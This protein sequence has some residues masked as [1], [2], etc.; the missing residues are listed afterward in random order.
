VRPLKRKGTA[1]EALVANLTHRG[2]AGGERPVLRKLTSAR[3]PRRPRGTASR[4]RLE[5]NLA[6]E[7][8]VDEPDAGTQQARLSRRLARLELETVAVSGDGNC[9]FRSMARQVLADDGR[10]AELRALAVDQVRARRDDFEGFLGQGF[11]EYCDAMAR[12][13]TWGDEIT[14]RAL[15]DALGVVV[16]V[17][18]SEAKNW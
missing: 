8:A 3:E 13:G 7:R 18:T 16:H 10:H 4:A 17:I 11:D 15:S 9:Q 1:S 6:R 12:P 2:G 14:L 5:R